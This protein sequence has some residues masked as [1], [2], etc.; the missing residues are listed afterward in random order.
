M[1]YFI[2]RIF[3]V[4]C[5]PLINKT[6]QMLTKKNILSSLV[7]ALWSFIGGYILWGILANDILM[8]NLGTATG[9]SKDSPDF[10]HL[11]LGCLIQGF[12]FSSIYQKWS[13]GRHRFKS[14]LRFG[15]RMGILFG[16]GSGMIDFATTN[17]FNTNGF[18]INGLIYI[19]FFTIMG[20]LVSLV[21]RKV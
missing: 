5:N 12:I 1:H 3:F 14:G 11:A 6:L 4:F 17:T 7:A 15:L 16:Y 20:I 21:S 18:L 10:I 9:V 19:I 13:S 8:A 2:A